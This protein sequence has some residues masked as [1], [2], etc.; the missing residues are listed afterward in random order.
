MELLLQSGDLFGGFVAV[1]AQ[2]S[3]FAF[4]SADSSLEGAYLLGEV[5]LD[6]AARGAAALFVGALAVRLAAVAGCRPG[7]ALGGEGLSAERAASGAFP[8]HVGHR[9]TRQRRVPGGGAARH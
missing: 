7:A 6:V 8:G 2:F 1:A 9:R 3:V 5:V 4:E